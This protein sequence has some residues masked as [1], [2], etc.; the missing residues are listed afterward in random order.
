VL[1]NQGRVVPDL[2]LTCPGTTS[3]T[4]A[5]RISWTGDE[6]AVF[7]LV[8]NGD[9]LY[10]GPEN[11]TTVSGR[12]AGNYLYQVSSLG[13]DENVTAMSEP[14]SVSVTP[15]PLEA[16]LG[17]FGLGLFVFLAVL[18]TILRGHSAH[19]RGALE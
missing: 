13:P 15:P 1:R 9:V 19:R 11:A 7:Q 18:I 5:Y 16:A 2:T 17:L 4:G 12:P 3:D 14:C 6:G 10:Q 8:E